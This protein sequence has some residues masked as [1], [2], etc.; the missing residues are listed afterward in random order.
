MIKNIKKKTLNNIRNSIKSRNTKKLNITK[1][2]NI[3]V[4]RKFNGSMF[5]TK[6]K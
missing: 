2:E 4:N 6:N 1:M 3:A 5:F